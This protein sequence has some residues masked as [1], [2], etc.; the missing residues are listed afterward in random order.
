[1]LNPLIFG[2]LWFIKI[3]A[4]HDTPPPP[5]PR[6]KREA[7]SPPRPCA[8]AFRRAAIWC[9]ALSP[10]T[11]FTKILQTSGSRVGRGVV[12]SLFPR[13][14]INL[15]KPLSIFK[16]SPTAPARNLQAHTSE[17]RK[18]WEAY[19]QS[20]A[21]FFPDDGGG[22]GGGGCAARPSQWSGFP[23]ASRR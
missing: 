13:Q 11:A 7:F 14:T 21:D 19:P 10:L 23:G 1:M 22:G 16:R 17:G 15:N 20:A 4:S 6:R 18:E 8:G 5:G 9:S 12:H 2:K 3:L